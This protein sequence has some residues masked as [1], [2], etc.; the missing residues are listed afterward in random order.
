MYL[1]LYF[2]F[3]YFIKFGNPATFQSLLVAYSSA[4]GTWVSTV[5]DHLEE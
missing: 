5:M 2:K 1:S 3:K 4:A